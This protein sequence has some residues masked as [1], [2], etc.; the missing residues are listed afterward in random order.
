MSQN[1]SFLRLLRYTYIF[2][3]YTLHLPYK[4]CLE[5]E[6]IYMVILKKYRILKKGEIYY[7]MSE[8]TNVCPKCNG[9]LSI[10]DSKRRQLI[11]ATGEV[12]PFI[13]HRLKCK[14]CNSLHLELPDFFVPHKHYSRDVITMALNGTMTTCPAE[15]ST[16]YRWNKEHSKRML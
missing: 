11:T 8:E 7:V 15:N 2:K 4:I 9:P 5:M 6:G 13:L 16:I 1:C 3:S 12:R 14:H 10:R